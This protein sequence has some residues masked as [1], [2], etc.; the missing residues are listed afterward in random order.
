MSDKPKFIKINANGN[1]P[2]VIPV[3]AICC[4][5]EDSFSSRLTF[6]LMNG[7][8]IESK[9]TLADFLKHVQNYADIIDLIA[10]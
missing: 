8:R 6:E 3:S 1:K 5:T 9:Y 7:N 2:T 4:I 10:D